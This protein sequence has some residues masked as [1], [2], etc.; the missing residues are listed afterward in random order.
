MITASQATQYLDQ[1]LGITLPAFVVSA[2]VEK[3]EAAEP[4]MVAAG[5]TEPTQIMVQCMAVAIIAAAGAPRRIQSQG[6]PSGAS[7][8]FKHTD[9]ALTQLRRALSAIDTAGTVATLVG[10]DPAAATLLMVV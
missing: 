5:Y 4:A 6:A 3:V 9:D 2:A 7:R 1:A 10:A 8:S